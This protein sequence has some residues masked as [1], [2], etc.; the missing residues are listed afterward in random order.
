MTVYNK[1]K[2]AIFTIMSSPSIYAITLDPI[3][4][5]SAPG[6]LLYAEMNFQQADPNA[7]LQVSLATP[8]DLS[9]LGITH[10]PPG[11]LNFYTR[12]NGQGSGVIVIT[13]SRPVIDPELNIVV[14]IS[15][16]SATRLQHIKTVIKPSSIKK[17]E[18][19]ES[20]L[21]P[22]F[23]VNEKDIALN[24]PEST[25]YASPTLA[26]TPTDSNSE[27]SLNINSGTAPAVNTNSSNTLSANSSTQLAQQVTIATTPDQTEIKPTSAKTPTN[28]SPKT[29]VKNL[30]AQK[31]SVPQKAL[32]QNPAKKQSLSSYKG[33]ASSGK[34]VVQRNES[35]WSIANRIAAK[36]KQPVAKVMH[37][38][39]TQNRHAFIQGD[40]NRLRQGI[41]LNLAHSPAAKPQQ[42]KSKTDIAHTAKSTSGKAKY[43]LQQA[44]M[45]I[46]A[47]NSQN[48]THG[49]A[50]KSTQQSQNNTELAVKVMTTREK[51]VTLQRN[52]TKLNQT[53]RLKDQRIQLLNARLAE[54]QQQLQAQQQTHKQKH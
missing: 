6:D 5:Q 4:I 25:R 38:I 18:N 20:T 26:S 30:T 48:S 31:K 32:N 29:P 40:V 2:I 41:A 36:T 33:P 9:A 28:N 23:I 54:L 11:N 22:Q 37:D 14:K 19:N 45:S 49:S 8:E 17:T 1:L 52:V 51:T 50:K 27:H 35:L 47:E 21:S 34:Y 7:N 10:Q 43:R 15:E 42:N 44:E 13:S 39:Q 16:G 24:L 53:L 12:Q 46:V 3:Q